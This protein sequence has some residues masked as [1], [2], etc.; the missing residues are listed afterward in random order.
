MI[1]FQRNAAPTGSIDLRLIILAAVVIIGGGWWFWPVKN[2]M[3]VSVPGDSQ[4]L[5]PA[6]ADDFSNYSRS[7]DSCRA[8]H[9]KEFASWASSNHGMAERAFDAKLD[10]AAF[11]PAKEIAH[12]TQKSSTRL[13]D[14]K[15]ELLTT[16][17][18]NKTEPF[19]IDR[20][21]GHDP[22]RQFL[23]GTNGG[24]FQT[25]EL[26]WDPKKQ[27]WFD[28][29]GNEDRK[30]GEW[31]HWT[32]R[33]MTWN[34]MCA[35]C[36]NTK[37]AKGYDPQTDVFHT[38]MAER[39]VSCEACHG[40]M[41]SHNVWQAAHHDQKNDPTLKK[42]SRDQMLDTCAQCHARRAEITGN[43]APGESFFDHHAL[44]IQW[45]HSPGLRSSL[46]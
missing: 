24:R 37:L 17:L 35:A 3:A 22:L 20:V 40:P 45:P 9:A 5:P 46:P 31:G 15:P 12:G 23:V 43:F 39:T 8:C 21:I 27:E 7:A 41:K 14:G 33:G 26:A 6:A 10:D 25:L 38:T 2:Y 16:S 42:L 36:H 11:E 34:A 30:P 32:G 1:S 13:H 18:A 44:S 28:I 19:A 29:Y 4:T